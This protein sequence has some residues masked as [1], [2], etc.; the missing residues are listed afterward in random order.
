[1]KK[2][3]WNLSDKG[4]MNIIDS[5]KTKLDG[6]SYRLECYDRPNT[7]I[8]IDKYEELVLSRA[9]L[10]FEAFMERAV[11]QLEDSANNI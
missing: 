2:Q 1:M 10:D 3:P 6:A 11:K 5:L 7:I 9:L 8:N 4:V